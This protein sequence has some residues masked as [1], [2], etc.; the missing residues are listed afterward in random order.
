MRKQKMKHTLH[1]V[2]FLQ[3]HLKINLHS[4]FP[5]IFNVSSYQTSSII[6]C[7]TLNFYIIAKLSHFPKEHQIQI[8]HTTATLTLKL[9]PTTTRSDNSTSPN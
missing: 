6:Y 9:E 5:L 2:K 3:I 1:P 4:P 7:N 8:K